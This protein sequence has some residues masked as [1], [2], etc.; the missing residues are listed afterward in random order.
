MGLSEGSGDFF[1]DDVLAGA[2]AFPVFFPRDGFAFLLDRFSCWVAGL[3]VFEPT[4]P[5]RVFGEV[6]VGVFEDTFF[7]DLACSRVRCGFVFEED[8]I[9]F[10]EEVDFGSGWKFL[11]EV[12][13]SEGFQS[14]D[15][16]ITAIMSDQEENCEC[17]FG[18]PVLVFYLLVEISEDVFAEL[19]DVRHVEFVVF[20]LLGFLEM[21]GEC[22]V[23]DGSADCHG[24]LPGDFF[25]V[26]EDDRLWVF[27]W[28]EAGD[29]RSGFDGE[30]RFGKI[31]DY[32]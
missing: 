32:L 14:S 11:F 13:V 4:C 20:Q 28:W 24:V 26:D 6:S 21:E 7:G 9:S 3:G 27:F 19:V 1:E 30:N 8:E 5:S 2:V 17:V 16:G 29:S 23:L 18:A 12:A 31:S 22:K 10:R 15:V 25:S